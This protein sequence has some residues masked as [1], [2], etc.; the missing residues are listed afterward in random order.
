[1]SFK[2]HYFPQAVILWITLGSVESLSLAMIVAC[3]GIWMSPRQ[4]QWESPSWSSTDRNMQAEINTSILS[5]ALGIFFSSTS[6][7]L[8]RYN[9]DL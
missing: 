9:G 4:G 5:L 7:A 6:T 8:C 1:M 3:V 2:T